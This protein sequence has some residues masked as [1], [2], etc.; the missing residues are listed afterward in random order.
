MTGPIGGRQPEVSLKTL[1]E[2]LPRQ[3]PRAMGERA[4]SY[5]AG[6]VRTALEV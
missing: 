5:T 3:P 1:A 6:F 4:P 2:R